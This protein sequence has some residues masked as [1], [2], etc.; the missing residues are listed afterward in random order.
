M[1]HD[2]PYQSGAD[3]DETEQADDHGELSTG[4]TY[5]EHQGLGIDNSLGLCLRLRG[6]D[7]PVSLARI[8]L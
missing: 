2:K 6:H 7:P 3:E 8:S 5:P 1:Q 4:R